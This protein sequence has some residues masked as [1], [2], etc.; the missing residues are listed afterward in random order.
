MLQ[1]YV[2]VT[3]HWF[4]AFSSSVN[5][6][7]H[8][9]LQLSRIYFTFPSVADKRTI[10]KPSGTSSLEK[11]VCRGRAAFQITFQHKTTLSQFLLRLAID[12]LI[13]RCCQ[14]IISAKFFRYTE[15][16]QYF[17]TNAATLVLC[18]ECS[19]TQVATSSMINWHKFSVLF[20]TIRSPPTAFK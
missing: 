8:F 1:I 16:R 7:L 3:K 12:R 13:L 4:C 18:M 2:A 20:L 11:G 9:I 10:W 17:L 14:S 5:F 15:H 19:K 6:V